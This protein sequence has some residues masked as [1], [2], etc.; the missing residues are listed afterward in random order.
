MIDLLLRTKAK[1]L[2]APHLNPIYGIAAAI[3]CTKPYK[4]KFIPELKRLNKSDRFRKKLFEQVII[5]KLAYTTRGFSPLTIK[6]WD[7]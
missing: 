3:Y 2:T 7:V 6:I 4:C 1:S 5:Y